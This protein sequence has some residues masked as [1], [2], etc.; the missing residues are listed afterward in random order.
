MQSVIP[1]ED[2]HSS[3]YIEQYQIDLFVKYRDCYFAIEAEGSYKG[4][5]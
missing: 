2:I 1:A 5:D 3:I 4:P